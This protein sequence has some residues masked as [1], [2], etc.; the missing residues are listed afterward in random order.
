MDAFQCRAD[1]AEQRKNVS[2]RVIKPVGVLVVTEGHIFIQVHDFDTPVPTVE[3]Q[4]LDGIRFFDA[5]NQP[6]CFVF[7]VGNTPL[8]YMLSLSN[9]P[10]PSWHLWCQNEGLPIVNVHYFFQAHAKSRQFC[11]GI[12]L[13]IG[14]VTGLQALPIGSDMNV[15]MAGDCCGLI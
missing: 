3:S 2:P 5:G 7:G 14:R 13:Q 11:G 12:S 10:D 9:D 8:S 4:Y 1:C 6:D 15:C